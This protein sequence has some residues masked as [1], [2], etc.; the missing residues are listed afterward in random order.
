M[1]AT[2]IANPKKLSTLMAVLAI[3]TAIAVKT[4]VGA[5]GA[6]PVPVKSHGRAAVSLF[7]LG[8]VTLKR[9]F[10]MPDRKNANTIFEYVISNRTLPKPMLIAA[11]RQ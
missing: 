4:G 11:F 9:L 8:L 6:K 10:A 2:H 1:E 5:N 7:S 3:A